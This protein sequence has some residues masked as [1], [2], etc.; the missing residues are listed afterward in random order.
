[1]Y[2]YPE[3]ENSDVKVNNIGLCEALVQFTMTFCPSEPCESL[4]TQKQKQIFIEPE[5]DFWF[6]M[7]SSS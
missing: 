5:K 4:H 2:Y 7:V 6:I 1:M 3:S